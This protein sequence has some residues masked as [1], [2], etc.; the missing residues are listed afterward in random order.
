MRGNASR[1]GP[2]DLPMTAS[3][4]PL[5]HYDLTAASHDIATLIGCGVISPPEGYDMLV[6]AGLIEDVRTPKASEVDSRIQAA[7]DKIASYGSID[8]A[9]HKQLVL[10]Q[11]V[12]ALTGDLYT[13]WVEEQCNGEDGPSTYSWETGIAP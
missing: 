12:R 2:V 11:V 7:L 9:H 10:D 8:G 3:T 6:R 1:C 4:S 5:R 13:A